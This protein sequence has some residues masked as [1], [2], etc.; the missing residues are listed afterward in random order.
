[1]NVPPGLCAACAH[2][3][4]IRSRTGS[5]F[6]LCTLSR[7]DPAFVRYPRLPVLSCRGYEPLSGNLDET[8]R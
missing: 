2:A 1:M 4:V 6:Y 3:Q 5:A 8:R 7:T